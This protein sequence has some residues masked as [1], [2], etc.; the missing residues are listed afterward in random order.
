MEEQSLSRVRHWWFLE[1][2][3][4]IQLVGS[5]GKMWLVIGI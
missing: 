4:E 1:S 5:G 3:F 2:K